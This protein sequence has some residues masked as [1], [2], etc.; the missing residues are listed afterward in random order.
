MAGT[1]TPLLELGMRLNGDD[2]VVAT[3]VLLSMAIN[4]VL[5]DD[6]H[7]ADAWCNYML[8]KSFAE[9]FDSYDQNTMNL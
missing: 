7:M 8:G 5:P 4:K 3:S 6:Q 9:N 2:P 1:L